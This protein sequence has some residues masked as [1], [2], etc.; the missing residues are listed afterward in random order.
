MT[1][2]NVTVFT[3]FYLLGFP[4]L[5]PQYYGAV[6]TLLFFVYLTLAG[7]NIFI[8]AFIAYERSLQKPTYLIY[9]ILAV[10]DLAFGTVTLPKAIAKYL[11]SI[12]TIS[13][14]SCFVQM[15]LVHYLG[16]INAFVILLVAIDRFVAV[17]NPLRYC[18]LITNKTVF[19]VCSMIWTMLIPLIAVIVYHA[20]DEPYCNSNIITQIYCE[21][22]AIIKLSCRDIKQ[23]RL[24]AFSCAMFILLSPLTFI[25]FSFIAIF[26]SVLKISNIQARYKTLS[27]CTPQL[28]IVFLYYVPRCVVYTFDLTAAFTPDLRIM[29]TM[30][31]NLLPPVVNPMIYCFR[32]K[33]I[34]DALRRKMRQRKVSMQMDMLLGRA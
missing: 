14:H 27:T 28:F 4:G 8:I 2:T 1:P 23:K 33:E 18:V 25:I 9:C 34:K 11:F 17:R 29:L 3:E 24:F 31:Y 22:N 6:G 26:T 19:V 7:G 21:R 12:D 13:F 32:T 16:S 15:F 10:S 30:W 5:H 20:L